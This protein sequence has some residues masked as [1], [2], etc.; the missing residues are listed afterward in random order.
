MRKE[1]SL[2]TTEEINFSGNN[3]DKLYP[4]AHP[5]HVDEPNDGYG[6]RRGWNTLRHQH[7]FSFWKHSPLHRFLQE[8]PSTICHKRACLDTCCKRHNNVTYC[9]APVRRIPDCREMD[10]WS[11]YLPRPRISSLFPGIS[12]ASNDGP[13]SSKLI[14]SSL[15]TRFVQKDLHPQK[16]HSDDHRGEFAVLRD[17]GKH[18]VRATCKPVCVSSR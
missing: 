8:Q 16:H 3:G 13:D 5:N 18:N 10:L 17:F 4:S 15:K 7:R 12:L 9:H 11:P 6:S 2:F 1:S 14:L